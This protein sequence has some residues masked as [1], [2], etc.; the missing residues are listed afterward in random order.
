MKR[1]LI[2]L[3]LASAL[4]A[5]AQAVLIDFEDRISGLQG[6]GFLAY[7]DAT[8]TRRP[9]S[10]TSMERPPRTISSHSIQSTPM[11]AG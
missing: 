5:A 4:P 3:L 9:G 1:I 2:A 11:A 7:P 6:V 10:S 8:F